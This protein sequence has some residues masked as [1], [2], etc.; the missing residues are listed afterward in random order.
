MKIGVSETSVAPLE[1][2]L[3]VGGT[4]GGLGV[5]RVVN[6]QAVEKGPQPAALPA[7]MFQR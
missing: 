1:G 2:K 5:M 4:S 6:V 7:L 3:W